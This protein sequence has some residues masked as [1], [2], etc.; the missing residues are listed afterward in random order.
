[1]PEAVSVECTRTGDGWTCLVRVGE[2]GASTQHE[3]TVSPEELTRYAPSATDPQRLVDASF[4]YLLEREPKESILRTFT[5][6]TI[7]RYF[8]DY[9]SE[10]GSRLKDPSAT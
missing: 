4:G 9:G 5:L 8:P 1:M 3:V 7:E 2:A 10:I 6:S